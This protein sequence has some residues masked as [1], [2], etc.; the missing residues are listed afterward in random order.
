[1]MHRRRHP[2]VYSVE[3]FFFSFLFSRRRTPHSCHQPLQSVPLL[4]NRL[5]V[6]RS[7]NDAALFTVGACSSA[8]SRPDDQTAYDYLLFLQRDSPNTILWVS[9]TF[10]EN[11]LYESN[12]IMVCVTYNQRDKVHSLSLVE[13]IAIEEY[14][15]VEWV[16]SF[17]MESR[18]QTAAADDPMQS[19][20][21]IIPH[22]PSE[23][24]V[25][26]TQSLFASPYCTLHEGRGGKV[27]SARWSRDRMMDDVDDLLINKRAG[28]RSKPCAN[29]KLKSWIF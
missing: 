19:V 26:Y 22:F 27:F 3:K 5:I 2:A 20:Y 24:D 7:S 29:E 25:L 28:R 9:E 12:K 16:C 10:E 11:V 17:C 13:C 23:K 18:G 4:C 6:L 14:S 21:S 15:R 8:P 1:M